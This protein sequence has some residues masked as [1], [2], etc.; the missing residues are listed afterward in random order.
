MQPLAILVLDL[1]IVDPYRDRLDGADPRV[2]VT[3]QQFF[4]SRFLVTYNFSLQLL[5]CER[6]CSNATVDPLCNGICDLAFQPYV[7]CLLC[8]CVCAR[9]ICGR[10]IQFKS[11]R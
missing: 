3:D 4:P 2:P 5:P 1:A 8:W 10:M 7:K 11:Q 9:R 6:S